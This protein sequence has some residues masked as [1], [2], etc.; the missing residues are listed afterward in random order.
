MTRHI[1]TFTFVFH[2]YQ[3]DLLLWTYEANEWGKSSLTLRRESYMSCLFAWPKIESR[4]FYKGRKNASFFFIRNFRLSN[5]DSKGSGKNQ[6][7]QRGGGV[8]YFGIQR[9]GPGIEHFTISVGKGGG[10]GRGVK[11]SCCPC[12]MW[13]FAMCPPTQYLFKIKVVV[14]VQPIG[15]KE[16]CPVLQSSH[17]TARTG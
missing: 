5:R 1:V 12:R 15:T 3:Y 10:G 17:Q 16:Y 13:I 4:I 9:D 2:W 11:C 6:K 8:N 7:F 14:F